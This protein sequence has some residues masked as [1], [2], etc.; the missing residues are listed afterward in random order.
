MVELL[1]TGEA[2]RILGLSRERVQDYTRTGQLEVAARTRGGVKLY[3]VDTVEA[4]RRDLE[5]R[6]ARRA[7]AAA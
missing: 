1:T 6:R 7:A 2:G 5:A 3:A 4:F